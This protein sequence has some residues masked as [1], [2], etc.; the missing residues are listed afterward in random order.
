MDGAAP[1]FARFVRV[2]AIMTERFINLVVPLGY[3]PTAMRTTDTA[4]SSRAA[5]GAAAHLGNRAHGID[6]TTGRG[7]SPRPK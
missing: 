1:H 6:S 5:S 2:T 4:G 3:E 7:T